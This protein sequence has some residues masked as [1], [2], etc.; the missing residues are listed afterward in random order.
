M[1]SSSDS[2]LMVVP[3]FP[4][5]YLENFIMAKKKIRG[6]E[7]RGRY[8]GILNAAGRVEKARARKLFKSRGVTVAIKFLKSKRRKA[9][10][11]RR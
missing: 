3:C 2:I 9:K 6:S 5:P 1:L 10:S 8:V 4:N 11:K 7:L